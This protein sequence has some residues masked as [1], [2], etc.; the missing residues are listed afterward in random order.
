MYGLTECK[1]VS[2]L[3]PE[4]LDRRPTSV[5]KAMPNTEVF[6]IDQDGMVIEKPGQVGELIVR[7]ANVMAGYWNLPE[8]TARVLK[9]GRIPGE[10]VL[11]TGDLF[12][13]DEDGFL[14]FVSRKDDILK[15]SGERVS[16]KEI[17]NALYEI[18]D[19]LEAAVVGVDDE[20]SGQ[21]IKAVVVLKKGSLL[22]E[23]DIIR[24]CARTLENYMVPKY[25]EIRDKL[26]KSSHGKIAKKELY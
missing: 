6:L 7:G 22:T 4:E 13:M 5:G 17:E 15:I 24:L 8:E 20:I 2:Y 21:A 11:R 19:I 1:R 18:E 3:P 14:Y 9:P 10:R 12:K 25:V 16:P 23:K 26:P